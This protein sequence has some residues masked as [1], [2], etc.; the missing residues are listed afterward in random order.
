MAQ[1]REGYFTDPRDGHRYKWVLIGR[2]IWMAENLAYMPKVTPAGKDGGIRVYGYQGHDPDE[3]RS[4]EIYKHCGCLYDQKTASKKAPP[5]GWHLPD[6]DEWTELE[7]HLGLPAD[8]L[9]YLIFR[10]ND[11]IG[12]KLKSRDWDGCDDCGFDGLPAGEIGFTGS[13]SIG[14]SASFWTATT[15][16]LHKSAYARMLSIQEDGILQIVTQLDRGYS[17][18][19]VMD[20]ICPN[21]QATIPTKGNFCAC[22]G[23]TAPKDPQSPISDFSE[24][25]TEESKLKIPKSTGSFTDPRDGNQYK[26][27]RIGH[28]IWMAENLRYLPE[29]GKE[30]FVYG[31]NGL[32]PEEAIQ[33][34]YYNL[35]GCLYSGSIAEDSCPPD[36]LLPTADDW[37]ALE[38][39]LGARYQ[40][41]DKTEYNPKCDVGSKLKSEAWDGNNSSGFNALPGGQ[42]QFKREYKYI[43]ENA[44]FWTSSQFWR[45]LVNMFFD[46]DESISD[47]PDSHPEDYRWIRSLNSSSAG[48]RRSQGFLGH[49]FSIRGIYKPSCASCGTEINS[50]MKYCPGCGILL[51]NTFI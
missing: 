5:P 35:Y 33:T 3:A 18:R 21:C 34:E 45:S 42:M 46:S 28:Q 25:S 24:I 36:W 49:A 41:L 9:S 48:I 17:I 38:Y 44:C 4:T 13:N 14:Q 39:K 29:V 11:T 19:C 26:W 8:E 15:D 2:Q 43:G 23:T 31:Y 51:T 6:D 40:D 47:G 37:R 32:D 22:C 27:I 20:V 10:E 12:Y 1:L 16:K 30:I 50:T 7:R